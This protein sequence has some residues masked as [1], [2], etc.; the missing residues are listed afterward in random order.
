M[1][2]L[3]TKKIPR[4]HLGAIHILRHIIIQGFDTSAPHPL[5]YY[6]KCR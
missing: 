3:H 5:A 2:I 1:S 6:L 4:L